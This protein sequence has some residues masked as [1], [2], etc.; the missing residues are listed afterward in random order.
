MK[1][2]ITQSKQRSWHDVFSLPNLMNVS[3]RLAFLM[4]VLVFSGCEKETP[5]S[6]EEKKT[7]PS[8]AKLLDGNPNMQFAGLISVEF[9]DSPTGCDISQIVDND[10]STFF[11]TP[12]DKFLILWDGSRTVAETS[13]SLTSANDRS[14]DPKSWILSASLDNKTW[15]VLDRQSDQ[16]FISDGQKKEYFFS[17]KIAYRYFK[18]YVSANNG[19][20]STQI[21]EWTLSI[22]EDTSLPFQVQVGIE[23][24]NMPSGG[25]LTSQ[26]S[27]S[28]AGANVGNIV[29]GKS[30]TKFVTS[31]NAF[32]IL[33]AGENNVS[34]NYYAITSAL[35]SPAMDPKE[36]TLSA[37]ADNVLWTVLDTQTGQS[38]SKR[39]EKK[40]YF[41]ENKSLYK[42]YKLE[43]T[44]N[45]GAQSTQMAEWSLRGLPVDISDLMAYSS[46]KTL[47][48]ITPM[49]KKFEGRHVTTDADKLWLATATNEPAL[50]PSASS[51]T[52][53]K[54]FPVQLYP[55]GTPLPA[56]VNQHAIGDC[57][58]VAILASF[59]YLYPDF[60]K[61]I[62]T[63]N[64]DKT[65]TVEMFD[66]QGKPV[67]VAVTSKFLADK[68]GTI[69][70][71]TG[72]SNRATWAT[73]LEKAIMKWQYIYKVN[74]DIGGI[75]S[76]HTAPLFT[77]DGDSFAF[78]AGK[79]NSEKLY[80][81]VGVS[82][83]QGKIIIGGFKQGD[84][85]VSGNHKTVSAHAFT[86][87]YSLDKTALFSM[88]N[89]WGG[90]DDGV[91]NIPDNNV[92]PPLIDL[93]VINPGKAA[94]Y[95]KGIPTPYNPPYLSAAEKIV[96]V[97]HAVLNPQ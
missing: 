25:V 91:Y 9:A 62:I 93:R 22:K 72:K 68:N 46:G 16:A 86:L 38:F 81:A 71:V 35:D 19:G 47:S 70:A 26:Y 59:A 80:R 92:I 53:W 21:S 76:E 17:N 89:P 54:D 97:S 28:P 43:I 42:Y 95:V 39:E 48:S 7:T 69:G 41:F 60:I 14:M 4:L 87:M 55:Y 65:Y 23:N 51:L 18:L 52:Q 24:P 82:L 11:S 8:V 40:E 33:W 83:N 61:A 77:G 66:P 56:D 78:S 36:W 49:G 20:A 45:N 34:V 84:I 57:S 90:E 74:E 96:R 44:A 63:D 27:D 3:F 6:G 32:Y 73:V 58:A 85:P 64:G 50:L 31:H 67:N 12:R 1:Q 30:N 15:T 37:S 75:G 94:R 29:D 79:L 88:R 13:Y 2:I 5:N 10:A